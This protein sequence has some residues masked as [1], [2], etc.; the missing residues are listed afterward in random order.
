ME[1]SAI[2]SGSKPAP[3][4]VYETEHYRVVIARLSGPETTPEELRIRYVVTEKARPIIAGLSGLR[5]EAIGI[6][7]QAQGL[8]DAIDEHIASEKAAKSGQQPAGLPAF[9]GMK[10]PGV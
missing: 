4:L 7:I 9:P 3:E 8:W 2:P 10:L 1:K 6:C 5:G